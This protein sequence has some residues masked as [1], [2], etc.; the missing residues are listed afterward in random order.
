MRTL[1]VLHY[2]NQFFGGIGGEDRADEPPRVTLGAVGPGSALQLQWRGEAEIVATLICGDNFI[3]EHPTEG[4]A[5]ARRVL[6]A[7][8]PDV[9][10]AGPAFN[11]GRYG[12][13]CAW[14][15]TLAQDVLHIPAVT[16]M[17]PENP[18][19]HLPG[20]RPYIVPCAASVAGMRDVL[21]RLAQLALKLGRRQPLGSATQE[22]YLPRGMRRNT[23]VPKP[24]HERAVSMLLAKLQ[25]HAFQS[26]IPQPGA[27]RVPPPPPLHDL[28]TA[29][30]A[31]VTEA[32]IV[33]KGNPDRLE[34]MR[35]TKW[36]RYSLVGR[37]AL[38]PGDYE[39][40]HG[41]YDATWVNQDPNRAVPV[42]AL[43]ALER[44]GEIG[45]LLEDY[46]VTVGNGGHVGDMTRFAAEIAQELK[47][48]GVTAVIAPAT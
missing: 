25:G 48:R 44:T 7:Y 18:G 8:Q 30:I 29:T 14:V 15:C 32:G 24:A 42:D 11:A 19:V 40:A 13:A 10:V 35:A 27:P 16:A 5:E 34:H 38:H 4:L 6:E 3:S 41:G 9:L 33:P 23:V 26:E 12:L 43:R 31:I 46:Y 20:I 45:R 39:S 28:R 22:G 37:D 36:A 17:H 2:L 47:A 21:P 1:R